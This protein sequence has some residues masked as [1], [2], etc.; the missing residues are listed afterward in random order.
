M[1][2]IFPHDTKHTAVKTRDKGKENKGFK[3]A[4]SFG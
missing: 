3:V 1:G 4:K 2:W